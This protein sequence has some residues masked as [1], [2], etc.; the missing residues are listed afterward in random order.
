MYQIL[1]HLE[2]YSVYF[3]FHIWF[4]TLKYT[5]VFVHYM[6]V[7][8]NYMNYKILEFFNL[9]SNNVIM[10]GYLP[11]LDIFWTSCTWSDT[12]CGRTW[13]TERLSFQSGTPTNKIMEIIHNKQKARIREQVITAKPWSSQ[14]FQTL[15]CQVPMQFN[16]LQ[17][18]QH[19]IYKIIT[20]CREIRMN[21]SCKNAS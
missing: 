5:R 9:N 3:F 4:I 21:W 11:W 2:F 6:H 17:L 10:H 7:K 19:C 14:A 13:H 18:R 12:D 16:C 15:Q 8:F 1:F 20:P